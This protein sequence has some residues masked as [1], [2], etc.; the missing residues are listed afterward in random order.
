MSPAQSRPERTNSL[1][2]IYVENSGAGTPRLLRRLS[3]VLTAS[4]G[5]SRLRAGVS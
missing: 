3:P 5:A 2:G 1:V 4:D